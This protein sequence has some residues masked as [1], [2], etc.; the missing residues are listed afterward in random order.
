M[1]APPQLLASLSLSADALTLPSVK[2]LT[3]VTAAKA[4]VTTL[5]RMFFT[6]FPSKHYCKSTANVS[7]NKCVLAPLI[8]ASN[9]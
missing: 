4:T 9:L 5:L 6:F 7:T 8:F 3:S 1:N 2:P